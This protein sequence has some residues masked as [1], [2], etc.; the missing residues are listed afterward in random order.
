MLPVTFVNV[1]NRTVTECFAVRFV[2]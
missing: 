1:K 2:M